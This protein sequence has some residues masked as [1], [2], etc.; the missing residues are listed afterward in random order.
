MQLVV[1][2]I[3]DVMSVLEHQTAI[4]EVAAEVHQVN[5]MSFYIQRFQR[6]SSGLRL[7][8]GLDVVDHVFFHCHASVLYFVA[9]AFGLPQMF[10]RLHACPIL[11]TE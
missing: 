7:R 11:I 2:R 8:H 1:V 10:Q 4:S 3:V 5:R 6:N 9:W